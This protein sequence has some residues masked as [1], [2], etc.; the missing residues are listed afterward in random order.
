MY[1]RDNLSEL[2]LDFVSEFSATRIAVPRTVCSTWRPHGFGHWHSWCQ[3]SASQESPWSDCHWSWWRYLYIP[4]LWRGE[5]P[6]LSF[7]KTP[8]RNKQTKQALG[9]WILFLSP[10]SIVGSRC[11][12]K[13]KKLPWICWRCHTSPKE[14]SRYVSSGGCL[15]DSEEKCLLRTALN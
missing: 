5:F 14:F 15:C 9:K 7:Q 10:L 2:T 6:S 3:H 4:Y 11:G 1:W 12:E 8:E 13:G